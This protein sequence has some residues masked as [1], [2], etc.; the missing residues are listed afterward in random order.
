MAE[1]VFR[2]A[3]DQTPA[4]KIPADGL[5]QLVTQRKGESPAAGGN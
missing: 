3:L 4:S 2:I 1:R 5:R